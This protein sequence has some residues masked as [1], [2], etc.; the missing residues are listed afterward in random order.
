MITETDR[1]HLTRCVELAAKAVAEGHSAFGS[2]IV[3]R[4]GRVLMEDYNRTGTGDVT[5]HPELAIARWASLN[6]SE[7]ERKAATVYTSCEHCAMCAAA[8]GFAGL[9]RIVFATSNDQLLTWREEMGAD[10]FDFK[11]IPARDILPDHDIEGP[12]EAFAD[13]V[14]ALH[15]KALKR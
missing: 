2:L 12:D 13:D 4:D 6:L 8:H 7:E 14:R 3:S 1:R 11:P 15:E 9:G 10:G 5:A